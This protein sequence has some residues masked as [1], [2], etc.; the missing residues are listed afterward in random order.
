MA[1]SHDHIVGNQR[2][3]GAFWERIAEHYDLN[4][5]TGS[6]GAHSLESKWG[7]IKHDVGKF[8]MYHK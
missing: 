3:K 2:Y 1:V 8:I 5:R 7:V 4:C 6:R